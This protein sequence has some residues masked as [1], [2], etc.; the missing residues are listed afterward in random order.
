MLPVLG[1]APTQ[2]SLYVRATGAES[3]DGALEYAGELGEDIRVIEERQLV[4]KVLKA[5]ATAK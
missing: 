4:K 5:Q 3:H 1:R 2:V